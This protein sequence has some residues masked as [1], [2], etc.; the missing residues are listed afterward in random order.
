MSFLVGSVAL[1][2]LVFLE[3]G[4]PGRAPFS[5]VPHWAWAGGV[6][7]AFYVVCTIIVGPRLGAA[8]LLAR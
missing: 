4:W 1:A 8:A 2:A 7:G 3:R 5:A 6:L